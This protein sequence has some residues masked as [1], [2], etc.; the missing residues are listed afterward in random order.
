MEKISLKP[1]AKLKLK[2][3]LILLTISLYLVLIG[4]ILQFTI[5]LGGQ[6]THSKLAFV[7]WLIA[8]GCI[9]LIWIIS[10]PIII[11]WIRNLEY[12]ID[13]ERI[14]IH[15]GILTKIQQ[16]IPYRAITDFMLHRSLYD[17]LLNIGSIRVQTAGQT[18]TPTGYEGN[19]A[20]LI[21]W[22]NLLEEL[23]LRVKK[24]NEIH[25]V[26]SGKIDIIQPEQDLFAALLKE[27][28]S[29]RQLLEEQSK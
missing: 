19:F 23:R 10:V 27:L 11:L 4:A 26:Q 24:Y 22:E 20:G 15:K 14:T 25:H 5:P 18:T 1:D 2:S 9:F 16:N 12:H 29:I 8:L 3:Y 17:R 7:L 21:D 28:K 6:V 13:E